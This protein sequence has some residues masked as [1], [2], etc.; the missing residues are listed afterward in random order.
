MPKELIL[1]AFGEYPTGRGRKL[2]VG[3]A[4][5]PV[6]RPALNIPDF[7]GGAASLRLNPGPQTLHCT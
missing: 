6:C 3:V 4:I 1:L 2:L 7:G 5:I